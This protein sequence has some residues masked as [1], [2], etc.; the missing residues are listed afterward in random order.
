LELEKKRLLSLG[1][2]PE[3][4]R[5][6]VPMVADICERLYSDGVATQA[7]KHAATAPLADSTPADWIC[8]VCG[9]ANVANV[10]TCE[11][12][13]KYGKSVQEVSVPRTLAVNSALPPSGIVRKCGAS[14]PKQF[15]PTI[16]EF[17]QNMTR[18]LDHDA[19]MALQL[20]KYM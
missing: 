11:T 20:N 14:R 9:G 8:A 19:Y 16:S 10:D 6:P 3:G 18:P 1:N 15:Q 13:V 7:K 4:M 17:A 2:L 12:L 5:M